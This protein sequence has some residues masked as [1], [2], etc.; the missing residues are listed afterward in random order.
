MR[1]KCVVVTF[2]SHVSPQYSV[3]KAVHQQLVLIRLGGIFN[4]GMSL[5]VNNRFMSI[6]T[7]SFVRDQ[8]IRL[9]TVFPKSYGGS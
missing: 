3:C 8:C 2:I 6:T 5:K 9:A 1:F 4:L 7:I